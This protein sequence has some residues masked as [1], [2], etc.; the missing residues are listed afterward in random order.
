LRNDKGKIYV[1]YTA[2]LRQ[3]VGDHNSGRG[4]YTKLR[5]PWKLVYYEAYLSEKDARRR[6]MRI[7]EYGSILGQLKKRLTH[8]FLL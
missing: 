2:N 4:E 3:R 6:E 8:S 5:R 7:K 1:G